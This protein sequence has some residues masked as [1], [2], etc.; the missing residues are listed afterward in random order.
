M[1]ITLTS[2]VTNNTQYNGVVGAISITQISGGTAPYTYYWSDVPASQQYTSGTISRTAL[3]AGDYVFNVSDSIGTIYT[4]TF[5][6]SG[7]TTTASQL[8]LGTVASG[9]LGCS[10][11]Y[12]A[13]DISGRI[14]ITFPGR[15]SSTTT[16][17][18]LADVILHVKTGTTWSRQTIPGND[19]STWVVGAATNGSYIAILMHQNQS[20]IAQ[21]TANTKKIY[22]YSI[23]GTSVVYT[24]TIPIYQN[25]T[26]LYTHGFG[27]QISFRGDTIC[28]PVRVTSTSG[29]SGYVY[30]LTTLAFHSS[31]PL[32][33]ST[34]STQIEFTQCTVGSDSYIYMSNQQI[35]NGA[36]TNAGSITMSYHDGSSW[37]SNSITGTSA[38]QGLGYSMS[39]HKDSVIFNQTVSAA[40]VYTYTASQLG[41]PT[42]VSIYSNSGLS[43]VYLYGNTI[44]YQT[45]A[46][47][48]TYASRSS[49]FSNWTSLS[50]S[51]APISGGLFMG[52]MVTNGI[53]HVYSD[54][55]FSS[56]LGQIVVTNV[57][58]YGVTINA[59]AGTYSG[60]TIGTP[61]DVSGGINAY[62]YSWSDSN[63][64]TST[65]SGVATSGT[66]YTL[67][68]RDLFN[69]SKTL[70]YGQPIVL[71]SSVTNNTAYNGQIGAVSITAIAGGTGPYN[72][73]W[74]DIITSSGTSY[75]SGTI[76]RSTLYSGDYIFNVTDS[77]GL[78]YSETFTV[79]GITTTDS[80]IYLSSI[81]TGYLGYSANVRAFDVNGRVCVS[82]SPGFSG[83]SV[84]R[85]ADV[86]VFL[87]V[88][89]T[90]VR[91]GSLY[92]PGGD[93]TN[94]VHGVSTNG[95]SIAV[96]M[97]GLASLSTAG[98]A[99]VKQIYVYNVQGT[100]ITYSSTVPLYQQNTST[101]VNSFNSTTHMSFRENTICIPVVPTS[102]S[103][104]TAYV[105]RLSGS[106]FS[107]HS[108]IV[109][110][111]IFT[112]CCVGSDSYIY[113]SNFS[114]PLGT[115]TSVG[116]V[117][118]AYWN[119]SSW[120][121]D[122]SITGTATN[123]FLGKS[124]SA[125]KD[126]V[127][128]TS[129]A[130]TA[131]IYT[132][133]NGILTGPVSVTIF[134][135]TCSDSLFLYENTIIYPTT[136]TAYTVA[137]RKSGAVNWSSLASTGSIA[138][139]NTGSVYAT[140][141]GS[142][143]TNG[144]D[145]LYVDPA[146]SSNVGQL[147]WTSMNS[148]V[149]T[150]TFTPG[151]FNGSTITAHQV[152]GGICK[153]TYSWS[154][155]SS[156]STNTRSGLTY[157]STYTV[158]V[159]DLFS[160]STSY[161]Y[162]QIVLT[163]TVTN[164]TSYNVNTN[165]Q[166]S[167]TAISGG[168][169][170]YSYYWSDLITSSPTSYTSGTISRSTLYANEYVFNVTDSV[171]SAYSETFT[172]KGILT[173]D[174]QLYA[175]TITS[176]YL[177]YSNSFRAIDMCKRV[178]VAFSGTNSSTSVSKLSDVCVF[179][180]TGTTWTKYSQALTSTPSDTTSFVYGVTT[181]GSMIAVL[182]SSAPNCNSFNI[183][184]LKKIYIYTITGGTVTFSQSLPVYQSGTTS[185][186][187]GVSGYMSFRDNTICVSVK[188]T[189][190]ADS[191]YAY[192]YKIN[193]SGIFAYHSTIPLLASTSNDV[194][195]ICR[196]SV[197]SDS[198]VY[199]SNYTIYN[200]IANNAGGLT[201]AYW[202]GTSWMTYLVLG[203]SANQQLGYSMSG[204]KDSVAYNF[205][206]SSFNVSTFT[207]GKFSQTGAFTA[208]L[209]SSAVVLHENTV[210]Y[211]TGNNIYSYATRKST[212]STWASLTTTNLQA[213]TGTSYFNG[214]FT[215]NGV[216]VVYTDTAFSSNLGQ[217]MHT[218]M[219]QYAPTISAQA[220]T[221]SGSSLGTPQ[222][223]G[224]IKQYSYKWNDDSTIVTNTRTIRQS[225]TYAITINDLF[226]NTSTISNQITFTDTPPTLTIFEKT[227][228]NHTSSIFN[229]QTSFMGYNVNT[230]RVYCGSLNTIVPFSTSSQTI[231]VNSLTPNTS[232]TC[233]VYYDF[234]TSS[235]TYVALGSTIQITTATTPTV[236]TF[237]VASTASQAVITVQFSNLGSQVNSIRLYCGSSYVTLAA[238]TTL[239]TLTFSSLTI[240]STYTAQIKYDYTFDVSN[241]FVAGTP[242]TFIPSSKSNTGIA[243]IYGYVNKQ[244]T[245]LQIVY[246]S[247]LNVGDR[248]GK[249]VHIYSDY[250]II[251]SPGANS[252]T[253]KVYVFLRSG[254]SV[255]SSIWT[256]QSTL[257]ASGGQVNDLFGSSVYLTSTYAIIGAPGVN[258][259]S[260]R[261][262]IF[263]R[264]STTWTQLTFKDP[265]LVDATQAFGTSVSMSSTH[266]MVG[267][268]GYSTNTGIVYMYSVSGSGSS[269]TFTEQSPLQASDAAIS[270]FFGFSVSLLP[271]YGAIGA[272]GGAR[273]YIFNLSGSTWTQQS[274]LS[275]AGTTTRFGY[276]VCL[277]SSSTTDYLTVG[278]PYY[279]QSFTGTFYVYIRNGSTWSTIQTY[280]GFTS[281]YLTY[282]NSVSMDAQ[283]NALVCGGAGLNT[284]TTVTSGVGTDSLDSYT[285]LFMFD[286]TLS[287]NNNIVLG[288]TGQSVTISGSST[289]LG[290]ETYT[291]FA[292]NPKQFCLS[293]QNSKY[294]ALTYNSNIAYTYN[295]SSSAFKFQFGG[296]FNV[297]STCILMSNIGSSPLTGITMSYNLTTTTL[298]VQTYAAGTLML[299][300]STTMVASTWNHIW[301]TYVGPST[302]SLYLNGT[303]IQSGNPSA[304]A[305]TSFASS[306]EWQIGNSPGNAATFSGYVANISFLGQVSSTL[307]V[308]VPNIYPNP[309]LC[310]EVSIMTKLVR[311]T[312][313]TIA[314]PTLG[315]ADGSISS[316]TVTGGTLPYTYAWTN[317]GV[318]FSTSNTAQNS[319]RCGTYTL[320][321]T[322]SVGYVA[323]S[324]FF[325]PNQYPAS[326]TTTLTPMTPVMG[327]KF[328]YSV[329]VSGNY[330]IASSPGYGIDA[331]SLTPVFAET[332]YGSGASWSTTPGFVDT[333]AYW[334]WAT[335]GYA[336]SAVAGTYYFY[337]T[338]VSSVTTGILHVCVDNSCSV[339]VNNVWVS[340]ASGFSATYYRIPVT[341][342]VGSNTIKIIAYNSST[343]TAGLLVSV[344]DIS[345]N[346]ITH[347]DASWTFGTSSGSSSSGACT[348]YIFEA[349]LQGWT[350]QQRISA[351]V[352]VASEQ[353]GYCVSLDGDYA[354]VG[355]NV[356]TGGRAYIFFRSG[357]SWT[358]QSLLTGDN[359]TGAYF[360]SF[361]SI[362]GAICAV[363]SY[364][365]A[366]STGKVSIY[367]R[368]GTTWTLQQS[369]VPPDSLP[370]SF[371]G[372]SI[373]L[374]GTTIAI[375]APKTVNDLYRSGKV[376]IYTQSGA[377]WSMQQKIF[378]PDC[379]LDD[380]FGFAL[381]LDSDSLMV[382]AIGNDGPSKTLSNSGCIYFYQRVSSAWNYNSRF[383]GA[384][385]ASEAFGT[386]V[387]IK[388]NYAVASS[389]AGTIYTRAYTYLDN[390]WNYM[391]SYTTA[392]A[393]SI[394]L[395]G[396]DIFVGLPN[397][398]QKTYLT[399]AGQV[400]SLSTR[401]TIPSAVTIT[402]PTSS[403]TAT[404]SIVLGTI[405]G[406]L[407]PYTY[408]WST[409]ATT[410]S[411]TSLYAGSYTVT[412]TDSE[413]VQ[414]TKTFLLYDVPTLS[415]PSTYGPDIASSANR[416]GL[417][418]GLD[419]LYM[420]T[421]NVQTFVIYIYIKN[422]NGKWT[423]QQVLSDKRYYNISI[424][425]SYI[426]ASTDLGIST[427]QLISGVWT[428]QTSMFLSNNGS[429]YFGNT[430]PALTNVYNKPVC[431]KDERLMVADLSSS[432]TI[433]YSYMYTLI[434]GVWT[435][436]VLMASVN[437]TAA[438]TTVCV[439]GCFAL[440]S[441]T[442]GGSFIV[443]LYA[444]NG[445]SWIPQLMNPSNSGFGQCSSLSKNTACI[446]CS[447]TSNVFIYV[448]D[449]SNT[450]TLQQTLTSAA[451]SFSTVY[452]DFIIF[453]LTSTNFVTY[454]RTNS[455]WAQAN[456]V[457][458]TA[459]GSSLLF[460]GTDILLGSN[461]LAGKGFA[462]AGTLTMY[463]LGMVLN[464]TVTNPTTVSGTNGSIALTVSGGSPP[465]TYSWSDGSS[466]VA[467]RSSLSPGTYTVTVT[468]SVGTVAYDNITLA[469]IFT[470]E[471]GYV[472]PSPANSNLFG[473]SVSVSGSWAFIT[474]TT[475]NRVYIYQLSSGTWTRQVSPILT[476]GSAYNACVQGS[477]VIISD[478]LA[479]IYFYHLS[480][481]T[482]SQKGSTIA[483][484]GT[485]SQ[486][487]KSVSLYGDYAIVGGGTSTVAQIY[488]YN[489]TTWALQ[490][491]LTVNV[492]TQVCIQNDYACVS[493]STINYTR[494]YK[495]SGT[496][497]TAFQN[498]YNY[499]NLSD[500]SVLSSRT[501]LCDISEKYACVSYNTSQYLDIYYLSPG[502]KWDLVYHTVL[503][504]S[505]TIS[506]VQ[507]SSQ[508]NY[509]AVGTTPTYQKVYVYNRKSSTPS[510]WVLETTISTGTPAGTFASWSTTTSQRPLSISSE[511]YV[512]VSDTTFTTSQG[513][514]YSYYLTPTNSIIIIPGSVSKS[515]G[516]D[517]TISACTVSGGTAPY[518]YSWTSSSITTA[519]RS[520]LA[521]GTY[522]LT[523]L[524]ASAQSATQRYVVLGRN[525]FSVTSYSASTF[526]SYGSSDSLVSSIII[527]GTSVNAKYR[528]LWSDNMYSQT[529]LT[530]FYPTK[531]LVNR[532]F[533][534]PG[535]YTLT[536]TEADGNTSTVSFTVSS[537]FG[538]TYSLT[539]PSTGVS[540]DG[541]I[542]V[543][544]QYGTA[545]YT[546][547][548]GTG[549]TSASSKS[550]LQIGTYTIYGKDAS[551]P[552]PLIYTQTVTLQVFSL[553]GSYGAIINPGSLANNGSITLSTAM[554]TG[555]TLPYSYKWGDQ[556][557]STSGPLSRLQI[558]AGSYTLTITDFIGKVLT[559][560]TYNL[561][562][563][564][565]FTKTNC[566]VRDIF[567]ELVPY[568]G[569]QY[570]YSVTYATSSTG[571]K[572]YAAS[573]PYR[574]AY[575]SQTG[576]I[577]CGAVLVQYYSVEG[578]WLYPLLLTPSDPS[579]NLLFGSSISMS[580]NYLL[581]GA[582]GSSTNQGAAY[583]YIRDST[584]LNTW[585]QQQRLVASD[586]ASGN[587]F[588]HS[589]SI[590]GSNLIIGSPGASTNTGKAYI[591]NLS[592]DVW[593]QVTTVSASNG[594][595]NSYF[596]F[597][598]ISIDSNYAVVGSYGLS[599]NTGSAYVYFY[600]GTSWG[601]QQILTPSYNATSN[602]FGFSVFIRGA[603][604]AVGA[605]N[606][607]AGIGRVSMFSR[608]GTTW[609]E[610][611]VLSSGVA[612]A[613][614]FGYSVSISESQ[615]LIAVGANTFT[616]STLTGTVYTFTRF[617]N[618]YSQV[619]QYSATANT[620]DYLGDAVAVDEQFLLAGNPRATRTS[621]MAAT[622]YIY[623]FIRDLTG[624]TLLPTTSTGTVNGSVS[625]TAN[626][627]EQYRTSC[628]TLASGSYISGV[629]APAAFAAGTSFSFGGWFNVSGACTLMSNYVSTGGSGLELIVASDG[630]LSI[631]KISSG[632]NVYSVSS[633]AN[634]FTLNA[635]NHVWVI[636]SSNIVNIWTNA[637]TNA[638]N[639]S[640]TN[641]A[642]F[643]GTTSW[644]IGK[645]FALSATFT[646]SFY[647][648]RFYNVNNTAAVGMTRA[649]IQ[650]GY[651]NIAAS[652]YSNSSLKTMTQPTSA[653]TTGSLSGLAPSL[654]SYAWSDL[655][656]PLT[657]NT[658]RTLYPGTYS[659]LTTDRLQAQ[660]TFAFSLVNPYVLSPTGTWNALSQN[661]NASS[662]FGCSLTIDSDY[663]LLGSFGETATNQGAAYIYYK[664]GKNG[665]ESTY[666]A[667]LVPSVRTSSDR[668]GTGVALSGL[669]ALI[670]CSKSTGAQAYIFKRNN[671]TWTQHSTLSDDGSSA[672]FFGANGGSI[673]SNYACVGSIG[674]NSYTGRAHIF[675][676]NS[677]TDAWD[678]QQILIPPTDPYAPA[679]QFGT[680]ISISDSYAV[681]SAPNGNT[682]GSGKVYVYTRLGSTWTLT[683]TLTSNAPTAFMTTNS[684]EGF[685]YKVSMSSNYLAISARTS[686]LSGTSNAGVVYMYKMDSGTFYLQQTILPRVPSVNGQFGGP[687]LQ[688]NGTYM[689]IVSPIRMD[690]YTLTGDNWSWVS[691]QT[692]SA[693]TGGAISA[694]GKSA[695]M[696]NFTATVNSITNAGQVYMYTTEFI[697]TDF[698]L[699]HPTSAG[700]SDGSINVTIAGGKYPLIA[701]WN[702]GKS[703][704]TLITVPTTGIITY[705]VLRAGSYDLSITDAS[706]SIISRT[707]RLLD[708]FTMVPST[709]SFVSDSTDYSI[710]PGDGYT[711]DTGVSCTCVN[712]DYLF[713]GSPNDDGQT[714]TTA[715]T[716]SGSVYV[717]RKSGSKWIM[718]QKL[719]SDSV[720]A[721]ERF[722][723][724]VSSSGIY[725]A[726]GAYSGNKVYTYKLAGSTWTVQSS[727]TLTGS[728]GDASF[729]WS[730]SLSS[731]TSFTR[732]MV[733]APASNS[734]A[735]VAYIY[736]LSGSV[737]S[738]KYTLPVYVSGASNQ[739]GY[740]VSISGNY[741]VHCAYS[742]STNAG[743]VGLH[744]WDAGAL[745]WNSTQ[746]IGTGSN[747]LGLYVAITD[748]TF[749][750]TALVYGSATSTRV[751]QINSGIWTQKV[752][753][754]AGTGPIYVNESFFAIASSTLTI[755]GF[756]SAATSGSYTTLQTISSITNAT[757]I[758]SDTKNIYL[759]RADGTFGL[760]NVGAAT[761]YSE[762]LRV[763]GVVTHPSTAGTSTGSI[764]LTVSGGNLSS[765]TYLW[766]DGVTTQ[767]R[768]ALP[769]S[770]YS[771]T[772]N[773]GY[774]SSITESYSL[775]NPFT[776]EVKISGSGS[777]NTN[778][779]WSVSAS[780]A[781]LFISEPLNNTS[782]T[783]AGA[784]YVYY[785]SGS[786]WTLS[787][788]IYAA[789]P[790]A[791]QNFGS[792]VCVRGTRAIIG[793][794]TGGNAYIFDYNGS[795]WTQMTVLSVTGCT[796]V[797][798]SGNYA[799]LGAP[800]FSS[801]TGTAYIYFYNGTSW[802][803]QVQL[804]FTDATTGSDQRG[805]SVSIYGDY[806]MV[807]S[808][809]DDF[810][811]TTPA[812]CGSV[813]FFQRSGTS[814]NQV[815]KVYHNSF[816]T[817]VVASC[818]FGT[819][820]SMG[821]G[822]ACASG[823]LSA[824]NSHICIFVRNSDVWELQ[825][826]QLVSS[827]VHN[828]TISEN[829]SYVL[830]S[831]NL[832]TSGQP[833]YT[834]ARNGSSWNLL[835][836]LT[837]S[838]TYASNSYGIQTSTTLPPSALAV[839][840]EGYAIIGDYKKTSQTG[841]AYIY[842]SPVALILIPGIVTKASQ[843][844][845]T[846]GSI[847][848]ASVSGGI[849]S[850][851]YSWTSSIGTVSAT[852][853]FLN[854]IGAGTYTL[855]VT[856][857]TG[858]SAL[859]VYTV[860]IKPQVIITPGAVTLTVYNTSVGAIAASTI[861]GGG[862]YSYSWN[863]NG[864]V[865][866][867]T[868][869]SRSS[870]A[871]G[872]YILTVT[873]VE[874]NTG[875]YSFYVSS[876]IVI[877][878]GTV[879]KVTQTG[880]TDGSISAASVVG[881]KTPYTYSWSHGS[882]GTLSASS[883]A[884]G[885][886]T[887]TVTDALL[888]SATYAYTLGTKFSV[889]I[890]PG[891]VTN[892]SS[893]NATDGAISAATVS[894]GGSYT[895]SWS[896][897]A[898][899]TAS[900][901]NL[902][903][904]T[905]TL[906]VTEEFGN[907]ASHVYTV[908]TP[909]GFSYI[910]YNVTYFGLSN[911]SI[912]VT[913]LY[914]TPPYTFS[915]NGSAFETVVT[916]YHGLAAGS[917]SI[918]IK[919]FVGSTSTQS[920]PV[921]QPA[922]LQAT[923]GS[924]SPC[925]YNGSNDGAIGIPTVSGG[926][927]PYSY[928]WSDS[929]FPVSSRSSLY[930]RS[931]SLVV[932]DSMMYSVTLSYTVTQ[933]NKVAVSL[934][935]T[936]AAYYDVANGSITP[937]VTGG[938]SPFY[939][940][941]T[942][943]GN[944]TTISTTSGTLSSLLPG[945][946]A[947]SVRD[948]GDPDTA[949]ATITVSSP[950][951]ISFAGTIV[952]CSYFSQSDGSISP[953]IS[954]GVLPYTAYKWL[955]N[956]STVLNRTSLSAGTYTLQVTDSYSR[957]VTYGYIVTQPSAIAISSTLGFTN[958]TYYQYADG[959]INPVVSGGTAPYSYVWS[960]SVTAVNASTASSLTNLGPGSYSVTVTEQTGRSASNTYTITEPG[961][962]SV[963]A[964]VVNCRY[965]MVYSGSITPIVSGGTGAASYSYLWTD[966][967]SNLPNRIELPPGDYT[968]TV[969]DGKGTQIVSNYTTTQPSQFILLQDPVIVNCSAFDALDGSITTFASGGLTPYTYFWSGTIKTTSQITEMGAG[970]YTVTITDAYGS[971]LSSICT[972]TEPKA[973]V[974]VSGVG[975][976]NATL[977]WSASTNADS[978]SVSY[979]K[980]S[981][982]ETMYR[983]LITS[984]TQKV[985]SLD[986]S[987]FYTVYVYVTK[988]LVTKL[989]GTNTFTTLGVISITKEDFQISSGSY[990]L[991][992]LTTSVLNTLKP[993]LNSTFATGDRILTEVVYKG[994]TTT[995]VTTFVNVYDAV[996]ALP[997]TYVLLPF[998]VDNGSNQTV[999]ILASDSSSVVC[1000]FDETTQTITVDGQAYSIGDSFVYNGLEVVISN[1001]VV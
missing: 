180:K 746:I 412:V 999:D 820:V 894:G 195:T 250:V 632:A 416:I 792:T 258:S 15:N 208:Y 853:S 83:T 350:M 661:S 882:L 695:C 90:W 909:F 916:G 667:R 128:I 731:N 482:W 872:T 321:V 337:N 587:L 656:T 145:V 497:W 752:S 404:G 851:T 480:G 186:V 585:T 277:S 611:Q 932:K 32:S 177:G 348:L 910:V 769:A 7:I 242:T 522:T 835:N 453:Y 490:A 458:Y 817:A 741:A 896:G 91:Q 270:R 493:D 188:P 906:T 146:F 779:G 130:T 77:L 467:S 597:R 772:V 541:A 400:S 420:I 121:I 600:N 184:A 701:Y 680:S 742:Y 507:I 923:A 299:T 328:G 614:Q 531:L 808:P 663:L 886:Y 706:G 243:Q 693:I 10:M 164:N 962:L 246:P 483:T 648:I 907:T 330:A 409:G 201:A 574:Y 745:V 687:G 49:S 98:T 179:T 674:H 921:T 619:S 790:V 756:I 545:P 635:W 755:Y 948:S 871:Q 396:R 727:M 590:S 937:T 864:S 101:Y 433:L 488:Y 132:Y 263:N 642:A 43:F 20:I 712:G 747:T 718:T 586:G 638:T 422:P 371:I 209:G 893:N 986:A 417:N 239:Q 773:D 866:L 684:S 527:Y 979:V 360:G 998:S 450:W 370:G 34:S 729:G 394:S 950:A 973:N 572:Y 3:Y 317:N 637:Y 123:Q 323:T 18:R 464:C 528:L 763:S 377:V 861:G 318:S 14:I 384:G 839:T 253:G 142:F 388:G 16:Q 720:T 956:D 117:T 707:F 575:S 510:D 573:S 984:T 697:M 479:N 601:Q 555:G 628:A 641:T 931:Y 193:S 205:N 939:Y 94:Y 181:S 63:V 506:F 940:T 125:Y 362:S 529:C 373:S 609:S 911:G 903:P 300:L 312:A 831:K 900:R 895:Y 719:Y 780:G 627:S 95:S 582:P 841:Q 592:G 381:S 505:N 850:Y 471:V 673:S 457:A 678:L 351:T 284:N 191:I 708:Q 407:F 342:N 376:Y 290:T 581:V 96:L 418:V 137:T 217:L 366:S 110:S 203:T 617:G 498:L 778:Y 954:G 530:T 166:I 114:A 682:Y 606:Y 919:D 103:F 45:S 50:S 749:Y 55:S 268:P 717:F 116:N 102:V 440:Q 175:G 987:T 87:K 889:I 282:G 358:Q 559:V 978:Y 402:H 397:V 786:S 21:S 185:Y 535:T 703:S 423:L 47:A 560:P 46:S 356:A 84:S 798:I 478:S 855:T 532:S 341:L 789:I 653:Y 106:T 387:S 650:T 912:I 664:N 898:V 72:Y 31:I 819:C 860:A 382:S 484:G 89:S 254:A 995:Q 865:S 735:G 124:I 824:S 380:Q 436:R 167:I 261:V 576:Y 840:N 810:E 331:V 613:Y 666:Q 884:A 992:N 29:I 372:S 213:T 313:P 160:N 616:T 770:N 70:S 104:S 677:T 542:V 785:N 324:T 737:W 334:I 834:L 252:L 163:S 398:A 732:L 774:G 235:G 476:T 251:G 870:L 787:Q 369:I 274:L 702:Y 240:G 807:G 598:N 546:Y 526:S 643:T 120:V 725:M 241:F 80:Q 456:T 862:I 868:T 795:T 944:V 92:V 256:L 922:A 460:N 804:S 495:R 485:V 867:I 150:I 775:Y 147:R 913:G 994:S 446:S 715:V 762:D 288:S 187:Y 262:Y 675:A 344:F 793:T 33:G 486:I 776:S 196:C 129:N 439:D 847:S 891:T 645:V 336:T 877:T 327:A 764:T 563:Q 477:R 503:P 694:D 759:V 757:A 726:V 698:T 165:G 338:F 716:N 463:S 461:T 375:G 158:I 267:S 723:T 926:I 131:G 52:S 319:L 596:G 565:A 504:T 655:T 633:S 481:S 599:T 714:Q 214:G 178:L 278:D 406:G 845:T 335:T 771:I 40:N 340:D 343:S 806:C 652:S 345:Q 25:G 949:S 236:S 838:D 562:D 612:S 329:S 918:T 981:G 883:L 67:Q 997:D 333:S 608:S 953:V 465:Y 174:V 438:T 685:G 469:N 111:N 615:N 38:S 232:Y 974:T 960:S 961:P 51:S 951:Q 567:S 153:Y 988:G 511:G 326:Y 447:N 605:Y 308:G 448:C 189:T 183:L 264:S 603:Y 766:N 801:S 809:F 466:T 12:R 444:F 79:K 777:S 115:L 215:T 878:P 238:V 897:S 454:A 879:S 568:P 630:T 537:P 519:S 933:P 37:V 451:N 392:S 525:T 902:A 594:A 946:Y 649:Y 276:S 283:N 156:I 583:V 379:S 957:V 692:A 671:T 489:G 942:K 494:V 194:L 700:S 107:Y 856:D 744:S 176:G 424:S 171:G 758:C 753:I 339:Y 298:S 588:G 665:W 920:V 524:D 470:G 411:I 873:E 309:V 85:L 640:T 679:Q 219:H 958:V 662:N 965:Y 59:T 245:N 48:Y 149:P 730:I 133:T 118:M 425:G 73:Y 157:G 57:S 821:A 135:N 543:S 419:G 13:I 837:A 386:L 888:V 765:Y 260:G 696:S 367:I 289:T 848:A 6:V 566:E 930:A 618:L 231:T 280:G 65:R 154:D 927:P 332:L 899:T 140:A 491:S 579:A 54:C 713:F 955:D 622:D 224:G 751:Y 711:G 892:A 62:T 151:T 126:S 41:T 390:T 401:L 443:Y 168:T 985:E 952:N 767:N 659:C 134:S 237:N 945:T 78:T 430:V 724:S 105:Y 159:S 42:S 71:T 580:G 26:S 748:A 699:A 901:T 721:S 368:N 349:G 533:S 690:I 403:S 285:N 391:G 192:V 639:N 199:L 515:S 814:W 672:T 676:Y 928:F 686:S 523:V 255:A 365:S 99:N 983:S 554:A 743:C 249:S 858:T 315:N 310:G 5:T 428:E 281:K 322:D 297:T 97:H 393:S 414:T 783:G 996:D 947:L 768:S 905:Y 434:S 859:Y 728:A 173:T 286:G 761:I 509:V 964:T 307:T 876:P 301:I 589:V 593:T 279:N 800:T 811:A 182:V 311:M 1000:E 294:L 17:S 257:Q 556:A 822:Y 162:N 421:T 441:F 172:V 849:P 623:P 1001:S 578:V 631:R 959:T 431:I 58:S 100:S 857:S 53:D 629:I 646:G 516:N 1:S 512:F 934:A 445:I 354:I 976:F 669:F 917:Y 832:G 539:T 654:L 975:T 750:P 829:G 75:T 378:A 842:S 788:T 81:A 815:Q 61:S 399:N 967:G 791:S 325:L 30:K 604:I 584:K 825:Y 843:S 66:V 602:Y 86:I 395:N 305:G 306:Y 204:F 805:F 688:L 977:S 709:H 989:L 302:M 863:D 561:V 874:G 169:A 570:G 233:Q 549:Y 304:P 833:V 320:T 127:I 475:A 938:K 8:V 429:I 432:G 799:I 518:T 818:K 248:F 363:S 683:Q 784:V 908:A 347:S 739:N 292:M 571:I 802:A 265:S 914:G 557:S 501:I 496:S 223:S 982:N 269:T 11:Y 534:I 206:G 389:G 969:I 500:S 452:N 722:G 148:V 200:G 295:A 547:D 291:S 670:T 657:A 93:I 60:S 316:V 854:N 621:Q 355:T 499:T 544:G 885:S 68:I 56:S 229:V 794:A 383:Y 82:F 122:T 415:L 636:Y 966:T 353:F 449:A 234:Q 963:N 595:I 109:T 212:G 705:T 220:G 259:G 538:F 287:Q 880:Y 44:L 221:N 24:G 211:T 782:Q 272:Y 968:L 271:S 754:V 733:G 2:T 935:K 904:G 941:W 624:Y 455:T 796:S 225:G 536:I 660:K 668:F 273:T 823:L 990:S 408:S 468:D 513:K 216:D 993:K 704:Q 827:D 112:Q 577:N 296:W 514:V 23:S 553:T 459:G 275:Q 36:L 374:S 681:I 139:T 410:S 647:D 361:V 226:N 736:T 569:D 552:S 141:T 230:I 161:T 487:G 591:F 405:T 830:A 413:S 740:A 760:T 517:G 812:D 474:E 364:G 924:V 442:V 113:L 875:E 625:Y 551:T 22:I 170:P 435:N 207:N 4:E 540:T 991:S 826:K 152:S 197:G 943:S 64:S 972:I 9:G 936:D 970:I 844:N 198:Y 620:Y 710:F 502:S 644:N 925:T 155:S 244:W 550:G 846:N 426:V 813:Y 971:Y 472:S 658:S 119:G 473:N 28:V 492:S 222:I 227:Y 190:T 520:A 869:L 651:V 88:S 548:F 852:T 266:L 734:N 626:A 427:F 19:A 558:Y 346:V 828:V 816:Q 210:I 352:P 357:T 385:V 564:F 27:G 929:S 143:C 738:N 247:D 691:A 462:T 437:V 293:I 359:E 138:L 781:W 144:T 69:N 314:Y 76:S 521:P 228:T 689:N 218:K 890:T 607:T 35:S 108:S 303:F 915:M 797:S 980:G 887:L 803:Q 881:G 74:S 508:G 136:A 610:S 202:N 634:A 39:A 836:T